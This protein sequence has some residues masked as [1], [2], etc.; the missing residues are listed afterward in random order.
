MNTSY[1]AVTLLFLS[2]LH[3]A[4]FSGKYKGA[5]E[6]E[7]R[8]EP[9]VATFRQEGERVTGSIGPGPAQQTPLREGKVTNGQLVFEIDALGGLRITIPAGGPKFAGTVEARGGRP[10]AFTRISLERVGDLTLADTLPALP[11]EGPY[12]SRHILELRRDLEGNPQALAGFWERAKQQG[13]PLAEPDP[14]DAR[15]QFATFVWQGKP[16]HRNVLVMWMPFSTAR[17]ADFLMTNLPNTDLWFRTVR[18]PK[19]ARFEYRLSPNDPLANMPPATGRREAVKDPLNLHDSFAEMP[20]GL[21]QPY[22]ARNPDI[23]KMQMTEH[24]VK[25][26]GLE[27]RIL[28]YT[29]PGYDPKGAPYPCVYLFDGE[30]RDGSVF[31][32][33]TLENLIAAKKLPPLVAVRIANPNQAGRQLLAA[34]DKF[35]DFLSKDLV[36]FVRSTYHVSRN[37]EQTAIAGYSLGGFA[38]A[39]AGLRHSDLFGRILSQS[40]SFW[41]EPTRD[42][43]AE[44][45]W[46][47]QKFIAAPRLPL[48]FYMDAGLFEVDLSGRGTGILL[49]NRHLR[50]VLRAKGYSVTYQEFPGGHDSINWR[51]TLADGLVALLGSR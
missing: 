47:A 22:Y 12:R 14:L 48:Q 51:G 9:L 1:A 6:S 2:A 23:P 18:V 45:T 37:A 31:A 26:E 3:A 11:G 46:I 8:R 33:W 40:G 13:T 29:P 24:V 19:G 44:P 49:P 4:D 50:D 27:R 30:D 39:C 35:F 42:E 16:E 25:G 10:S 17:P 15:F 43:N 41:I 32:T 7:S 5:L 21:P 28:I 38:A 36:P 20:A 34:N